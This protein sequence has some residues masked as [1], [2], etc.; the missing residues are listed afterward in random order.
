MFAQMVHWE[1]VSLA[2]WVGNS[3]WTSV[4]GCPGQEVIGINGYSKW[5]ISPT[6]KWGMNWGYNGITHLLTFY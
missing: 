3:D 2:S 4:L 5:A 1:W 6:Y